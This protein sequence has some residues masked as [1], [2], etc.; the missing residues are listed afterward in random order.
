MNNTVMAKLQKQKSKKHTKMESPI[1]ELNFGPDWKISEK[2]TYSVHNR[3]VNRLNRLKTN[4]K[5][6]YSTKDTPDY[7][8]LT[9]SIFSLIGNFEEVFV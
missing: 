1:S 7:P 9:R 5:R 3:L 8:Q 2:T 4:H 6:K